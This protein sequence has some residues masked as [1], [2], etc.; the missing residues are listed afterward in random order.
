MT[1]D[2]NHLGP[3][4]KVKIFYASHPGLKATP[5]VAWVVKVHSSHVVVRWE[6]RGTMTISPDGTVP[7]W[8]ETAWWEPA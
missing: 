2:D 3:G 1:V 8:G 6:G 5:K 4:Q 7:L